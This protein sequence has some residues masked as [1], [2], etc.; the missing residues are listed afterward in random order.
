MELYQKQATAEYYPS[1]FNPGAFKLFEEVG[2]I[3]PY[4]LSNLDENELQ[5]CKPS[6]KL[7]LSTKTNSKSKSH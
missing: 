2:Y 3:V 7:F 4:S 6:S 1:D 5:Y